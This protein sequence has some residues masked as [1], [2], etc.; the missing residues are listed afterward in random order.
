MRLLLDKQDS[1]VCCFHFQYGI[2]N[3][4]SLCLHDFIWNSTVTKGIH[5]QLSPDSIQGLEVSSNI[6]NE[7]QMSFSL[8]LKHFHGE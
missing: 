3:P 5:K 8:K 7:A 6:G 2:W 4:L 1:A